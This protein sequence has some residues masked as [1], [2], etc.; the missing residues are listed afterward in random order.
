MVQTTAKLRNINA[1]GFDDTYFT[2]DLRNKN[3]DFFF[4]TQELHWDCHVEWLRS[5]ASNP[6]F[7]FYIIL[8]DNER[9]GTIAVEHR[10]SC[11]FLQNLCVDEKFRG[12]GLAKFAITALMKPG[13]FIVAQV[14][15]DN[16]HVIKMYQS[17]GFWKV[18]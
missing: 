5:K 13:R 14:K 15:T 16:S 17:L 8:C 9:A 11:E 1:W 4:D 3:K 12:R 2:F 6:A 18:K 10:D 7:N